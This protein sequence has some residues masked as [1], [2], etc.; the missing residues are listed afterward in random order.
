MTDETREDR[1][2]EAF[3]ELAEFYDDDIVGGAAG[4]DSVVLVA[5]WYNGERFV[6]TM[7]TTGNAVVGPDVTKYGMLKWAEQ[8]AL[9]WL[10]GAD[11][12][13]DTYDEEEGDR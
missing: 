7:Y 11:P 5:R 12:S 2:R 6:L 1:L 4:V 10:V 8:V 3:V 9:G 13:D